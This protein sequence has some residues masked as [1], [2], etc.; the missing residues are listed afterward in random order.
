MAKISYARRAVDDLKRLSE[1]LFQS[2]PKASYETTDLILD[3]ICI[4]KRHPQVGRPKGIGLRELVISRGNTGYVAL[5]DYYP[6]RDE[7]LILKIRHQREIRHR[8]N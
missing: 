2:D 6:E 5:Y 8:K 4:L 1:F 3:A 7:V